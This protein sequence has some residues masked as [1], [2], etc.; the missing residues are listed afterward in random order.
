ML[1]AEHPQV[2]ELLREQGARSKKTAPALG[3]FLFLQREGCS[4]DGDRPPFEEEL[5]AALR[6]G[7]CPLDRVYR[8]VRY[9]EIYARYLDLFERQGIIMRSGLTPTDAAHVL[10]RYVDWD[11]EAARLG[12]EL[13]SRRVGQEVNALCERILAQTSERIAAEVVTKL[14][15]DDGQDGHHDVLESQLVARALRPSPTSALQCTL[16]VRP[17]IVAIGAPV[18]TYFPLVSGLLHN[19]LR[20]PEHTEVANAVGAVVGSVVNR[21]YI[22]IVPQEEEG[23]FRVHLPDQVQDFQELEAAVSFAEDYG[24]RLASDGARRAGAVDI[25]LQVDRRDQTATVATGWGED[26]YLQT[27]LEVTAVG[28]PRLAHR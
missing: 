1:A 27:V 15:S 11:R 3:E 18:R 28:R 14:L 12:A 6:V 5:M 20:I 13:L 4:P 21:V 10:G 17:A 16:T 8:I 7:P 26:V 23:I 9:P 24:R 22:L 2:V 25:R 19:A